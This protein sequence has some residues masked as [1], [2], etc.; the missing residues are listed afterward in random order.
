VNSPLADALSGAKLAAAGIAA[1]MMMH[2]GVAEAGVQFVKP[3]V[4]KVELVCALL[5]IR[6]SFSTPRLIGRCW[7]W[8]LCIMQVFQEE[9]GASNVTV[10]SSAAAPKVKAEPT[11]EPTGGPSP[12][13]IGIPG[14]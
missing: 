10:V 12:A 9:K 13:A 11:S 7:H 8:V 3:E 2:V 14:N 1:G 6:S 4:K 5:F